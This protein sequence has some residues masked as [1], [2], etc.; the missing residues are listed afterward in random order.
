VEYLGNEVNA[1][2]ALSMLQ[3]A[4]SMGTSPDS[5]LQFIDE[6]AEA[7]VE[8]EAFLNLKRDALKV[9]LED[10]NLAIDEVPLMDAVVKWGRAEC[11][12]QNMDDKKDLK[13]A[14]SDIIPLIRFPI[15]TVQEL[16]TTV[17]TSGFLDQQELVLMFAYC[18]M[19][20]PKAKKA[21]KVPFPTKE[22]ES[23][24]IPKESIILK[25]E[26]R[27]EFARLFDKKK[28]TF[29]LLFR[30][31][32]DGYNAASFHSKC[33]AKGPTL[34]VV[35]V[36]NNVFGGF[37]GESW[38]TSSNY[39]TGNSWLFSLVNPQNSPLKML[40]ITNYNH[41]YN[42]ISYGPTFGGG[43]DMYI[44]SSMKSSNSSSP[45][46]YTTIAPNYTGYFSSTT[47]T[48]SSSFVVEE[49][50]VFSCKIQTS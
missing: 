12:R 11:K 8:T 21:M 36:G 16:A 46:S 32:T 17:A 3:L 50:E 18:S 47:F 48:G 4:T 39:T 28:A 5:I 29:K 38:G 30:G 33:D 41:C 7:V 10:D 34:T 44:S 2:N 31:A 20:D 23:S 27:K 13:K 15:M 25:G 22:R 14:L 9:L 24:I 26:H 35:K 6:N 45:S 43:H 49:I 19:T 1:E 40:N 37:N 42:D